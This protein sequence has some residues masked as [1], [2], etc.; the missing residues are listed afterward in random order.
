MV[1]VAFL[2][3]KAHP[4]NLTI[5]IRQFY[6]LSQGQA[7]RGQCCSIAGSLFAQALAS[8]LRPS[9]ATVPPLALLMGVTGVHTCSLWWGLGPPSSP[10][11][12]H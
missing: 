5:R 6:V 1:T 9:C 3:K 12:V 10:L 7:C 4:V 8:C 2:E 11:P